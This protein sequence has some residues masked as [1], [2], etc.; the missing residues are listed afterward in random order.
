MCSSLEDVD[1]EFLQ[2]NLLFHCYAIM[3]V[4]ILFLSPNGIPPVCNWIHLDKGDPWDRTIDL[5][6]GCLLIPMD[7]DS[8]FIYETGFSRVSCRGVLPCFL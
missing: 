2:F 1:L 6:A 3:S 5:I 7:F 4:I 8:Q